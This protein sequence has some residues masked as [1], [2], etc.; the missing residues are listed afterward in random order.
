[1]EQEEPWNWKIKSKILHCV[2]YQAA[3]TDQDIK[4]YQILILIWDLKEFNEKI[5]F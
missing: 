2:I 1:M 4:N 5:H 3:F